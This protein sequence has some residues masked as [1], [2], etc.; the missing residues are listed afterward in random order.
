MHWGSG[1]RTG[2]LRNCVE[3]QA[4]LQ[5]ADGVVRDADLEHIVWSPL[6]RSRSRQAGYVNVPSGATV[7]HEA[8]VDMAPDPPRPDSI[9]RPNISD[10]AGGETAL[11]LVP[12]ARTALEAD[13]LHLSGGSNRLLGVGIPPNR[14]ISRVLD[15]R[16]RA[17]SNPQRVLPLHN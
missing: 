15:H 4:I 10:T 3:D 2:H 14:P 8:V 6:G 16:A 11:T 9:P 17:C 12:A 13:T 7:A 5:V 1:G